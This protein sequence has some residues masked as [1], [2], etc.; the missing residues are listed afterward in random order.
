MKWTIVGSGWISESFAKSLLNN[1]QEIVAIV[2]RSEK[3]GQSFA[4]KFGIKNVFTS[5]DQDNISDVVYVATPNSLHYEVA[6]K[7]L[8]LNKHVMVE[9]PFT[10]SQKTTKELFE[11]AQKKGL[12]IMEA[13]AHITQPFF[14]NKINC[15]NEL[16]VNYQQL[17]SK[18][19]DNS[20]KSASSFSKELFGGVVADLGVYPLSCA[21]VI[22]GD[23]KTIEVNNVEFLNNVVSSASI[24]LT[25]NNEKISYIEISKT[26]DGDN[27]LYLDNKKV[28]KHLNFSD[29]EN[30]M[31][32][33]IA[34]F[35]EANTEVLNHFKNISIEVAKIVDTI[36]EI[37]Y[38]ENNE[39]II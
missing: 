1:S 17:S 35:V 16:K 12:R 18:I 22:N 33:E 15:E 13:Y 32:Q 11:I 31:D 9:K 30:K 8:S 14:L 23:V 4:D 10:H 37:V 2:S 19:K 39:K 27:A 7:A 21:V 34:L 3:S 24:K 6:L 28:L 25:H 36:H 26:I 5:L 38:K 29:V 20:Y